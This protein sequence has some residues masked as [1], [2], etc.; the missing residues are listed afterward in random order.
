MRILIFFLGLVNESFRVLYIYCT[1]GLLHLVIVN[2]LYTV[3]YRTNL[4]N[5]ILITKWFMNI[6]IINYYRTIVNANLYHTHDFISYI[7]DTEQ[8]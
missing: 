4:S 6:F 1:S 7:F 5:N 3:K 2:N 8:T